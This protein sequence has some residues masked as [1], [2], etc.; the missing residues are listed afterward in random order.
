MAIACVLT[1]LVFAGTAALV[2]YAVQV[3]W[4]D[5]AAVRAA[6]ARAVARHARRSGRATRRPHRAGAR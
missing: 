5:L 3:A 6:V 4:T 1:V 2:V